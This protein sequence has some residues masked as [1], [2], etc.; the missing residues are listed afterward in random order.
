MALLC[1]TK[2]I[3]CISLV[4][5]QQ[6]I[7]KPLACVMKQITP[8]KL[9]EEID[10]SEV[11]R[12]RV[13]LRYYFFL[14]YFISALNLFLVLKITSNSINY[15]LPHT[16]SQKD[17]FR[18][19]NIFKFLQK[20][21][22]IIIFVVNILKTWRKRFSTKMMVFKKRTSGRSGNKLWFLFPS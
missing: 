17:H 19:K 18:K 4:F 8:N 22:L 15:S 7:S 2:S 1:V 20:S 6:H 13:K 12:L 14:I 21:T 5:N 3:Q 9:W 16:W 11:R 10:L